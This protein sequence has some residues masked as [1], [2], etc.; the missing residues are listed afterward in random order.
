MALTA[1]LDDPFTGTN[2]DPIDGRA[3][4]G[5]DTWED[6]ANAFEINGNQCRYATSSSFQGAYVVGTLS[7]V[8]QASEATLL[9]A[10]SGVTTR[11]QGAGGSL[12]Y[13][14]YYDGGSATL[15]RSNGGGSFTELEA[16]GESFTD[17]QTMQCR[18]VADFHQVWIDGVA[19]GSGATDATYT[20]GAIGIYG[21]SGTGKRYEDYV[22]YLEVGGP[23]PI[24]GDS[25]G[26][27]GASSA[28]AATV[29]TA[30]ASSS[31]FGMTAVAVATVATSGASSA[32]LGPAGSNVG[33][34]ATTGASDSRL[35]APGAAAGAVATTGAAAASAG[36]SG[37]QVAAVATTGAAAAQVGLAGEGSVAA[38]VP[39][40]AAALLGFAC[41]A[42]ATVA[43]TAHSTA[44]LGIGGA[45][46]GSVASSGASSARVGLVGAASGGAAPDPGPAVAQRSPPARRSIIPRN[47][48]GQRAGRRFPPR[49]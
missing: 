31:G 14:A 3:L 18:S 17:G 49:A 4:N 37:A 47:F 39:A 2:G 29:A 34:V 38:L 15:Y 32:L 26:T 12:F 1:V 45:G 13:L 23:G 10:D 42:A 41:T 7:E 16:T 48:W 24:A 40:A 8:D 25:A 44:L 22:G 43:I 28:A 11:H 30:G 9:D 35:G 5:G 19:V 20:A 46:A 33:A 21:P 27:I 6:P 36:A